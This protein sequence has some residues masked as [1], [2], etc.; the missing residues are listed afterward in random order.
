MFRVTGMSGF[1]IKFDSGYTVSVQFGPGNYGSN[2]DMPYGPTR[3]ET[4]VPPAETAEIAVFNP[5]HEMIL[6]D[7]DQVDGYISADKV[8][9]V[10]NLAASVH[11]D[12]EFTVKYRALKE[13]LDG[14]K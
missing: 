14:P 8:L 3:G 13:E 12:E 10:F 2:Y 9:R 4:P 7:D 1:H 6:L 5:D 11:G